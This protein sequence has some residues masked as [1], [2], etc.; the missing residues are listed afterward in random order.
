[1][2]ATSIDWGDGQAAP[3][4]AQN[5]GPGRNFWRP[6]WRR[7]QRC[8]APDP[9]SD[10][11]P[12]R[13]GW[14]SSPVL[15]GQAWWLE[16]N[17]A[18]RRAVRALRF[19][20]YFA[21][22]NYGRKESGWRQHGDHLVPSWTYTEGP[23][24][25]LEAVDP[26]QRAQQLHDCSGSW[27]VQARARATAWGSPDLLALPIPRACNQKHV[28]PVC[29]ARSSR[30]LAR[31]IRAA[32]SAKERPAALALVTLTHKADEAESLA[33]ALARW[34][35][36]WDLMT[37][38]RAGTRFGRF[39][40]GYYY[41]LEVTYR[42]GRGWHLHCHM[43]AELLE[44]VTVDQA[45]RYIGQEWRRCTE[46]A[47]P[48]W[49]WDPLAGCWEKASGE[50]AS[51]V[52]ARIRSGDYS[53]PWW[54]E[55]DPADLSAVYQACKYPTPVVDL[56]PPQ[57]VEFLA[58]THGRI[59]HR[60]GLGWRSIR[61][62]G[63]AAIAEELAAEVEEAAR[64]DLGRAICSMAPG[65]SPDLDHVLKGRG[66][67]PRQVPKRFV[68]PP[69]VDN[70]KQA[71]RRA[72][73]TGAGVVGRLAQGIE[74]Y[75]GAP[76]ELQT[77]GVTWVLSQDEWPLARK[78]EEEGRAVAGV[79]H[80]ERHVPCRADDDGAEVATIRDER[81]GRTTVRHVRKVIREH[82]TITL[83]SSE[84]AAL[85]RYTEAL[86]VSSSSSSA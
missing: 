13:N 45:R 5:L 70:P 40:A 22:R 10:A 62:E 74:L 67:E 7:D 20:G 34:R 32:I 63:Q 9:K 84:A 43:V 77:G 15:E 48:S 33:D 36:A 2:T 21:R 28:C 49:G 46:A 79:K 4:N 12:G 17:E 53:G 64:V 18:R 16:A 39:I 26:W 1:M 14:R 25:G 68:T 66:L 61:R 47:R 59:W 71:E 51:A 27:T 50:E 58:A 57:L 81:S 24:D 23:V 42:P 31:E 30:A 8:T 80:V 11:S 72:R 35:R 41:G 86:L 82:P 52:R 78:L 65:H 76:G 75:G 19:A 6:G 56:N 85:V 83:L 60:G 44:G 29:A 55:I 54:R 69:W 38:G 37:K 73:A 3:R